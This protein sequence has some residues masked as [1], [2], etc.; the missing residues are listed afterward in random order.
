LYDQF[1]NGRYFFSKQLDFQELIMNEMSTAELLE[2]R[3]MLESS[4]DVQFQAWMAITFAVIVA[5]YSGRYHLTTYVRIAIST[6]YVM[7]SYA[8]FARWLTEGLRIRQFAEVLRDR[9]VSMDP[10]FGSD[11]VRLATYAIG[12]L[13]TVFAIFYFG[14]SEIGDDGKLHEQSDQ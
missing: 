3:F 1:E 2:L 14:R 12:T 7:A 4:I 6:A 8:L 13:I 9:G 11:S 5:S 10:M